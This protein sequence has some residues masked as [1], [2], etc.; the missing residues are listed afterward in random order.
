MA[1]TIIEIIDG[2]Y[3]DVGE[4]QADLISRLTD[5]RHI[6]TFNMSDA[7]FTAYREKLKA[8]MAESRTFLDFDKDLER[9]AKQAKSSSFVL[10]AE[11][12]ALH[13][14]LKG[15]EEQA[16]KEFFDELPPIGNA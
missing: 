9:A 11:L 13:K 14:E 1:K 5:I 15:R 4:L 8:L 2:L 6:D 16:L 10:E 7:E 3:T 12:T